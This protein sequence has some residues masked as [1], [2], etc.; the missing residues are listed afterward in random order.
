MT[1][2]RRAAAAVWDFIVGDDWRTAVGVIVVLGATAIVAGGHLAA[3]WIAAVAVPAL[4]AWS[5]SRE[6][7]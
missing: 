3:W 5:V 1:A 2:L 6:S 7:R 4:L